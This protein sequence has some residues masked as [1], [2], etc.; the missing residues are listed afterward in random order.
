MEK[1][2]NKLLN[3]YCPHERL[4]MLGARTHPSDCHRLA[5]V[6]AGKGVIPLAT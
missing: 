3:A 1:R 4:P 6:L 2:L 5:E